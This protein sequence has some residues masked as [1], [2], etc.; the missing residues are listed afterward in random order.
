VVKNRDQ[1]WRIGTNGEEYEP[2]VKNMNQ[3]CRIE[4]SIGG[5]EPEIKHS[6]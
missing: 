1:W 6:V 2:M 4:I 3:W 5:Y